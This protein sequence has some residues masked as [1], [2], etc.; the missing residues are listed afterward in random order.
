MLRTDCSVSDTCPPGFTH[1]QAA[2]SCYKV[3]YERY[4]WATAGTKCQLLSSGSHLA[5]IRSAAEN[6][7]LTTFLAGEVKSMYKYEHDC[8]TPIHFHCLVNACSPIYTIG[9]ICVRNLHKSMRIY[10]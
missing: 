3:I 1:L 5:T 6:D 7:A 2:D 10:P 8:S 4:D 9:Y